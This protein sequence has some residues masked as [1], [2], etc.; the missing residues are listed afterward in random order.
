MRLIWSSQWFFR[1]WVFYPSHNVLTLLE[2]DRHEAILF[3]GVSRMDIITGFTRP[4]IYDVSE[5]ASELYP[6]MKLYNSKLYRIV[7][8]E[9]TFHIMADNISTMS[10]F[11]M[12]FEPNDVL[13][14]HWNK[15]G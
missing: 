10:D 11:P 3:A 14:G 15:I 9:G 4:K 13:F 8:K 7:S 12:T 6:D 1:V 2:Y 5:L